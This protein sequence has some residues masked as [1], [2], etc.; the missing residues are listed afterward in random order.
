MRAWEVIIIDIVILFMHACMHGGVLKQILLLCLKF[1][2][3]LRYASGLDDVICAD[4]ENLQHVFLE[5]LGNH[6]NS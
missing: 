3:T 5:H 1:R 4:G 2:I 6:K